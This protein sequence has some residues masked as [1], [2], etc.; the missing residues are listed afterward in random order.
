MTPPS[1]SRKCCVNKMTPHHPPSPYHHRESVVSTKWQ[2]TSKHLQ[3]CKDSSKP[4]WYLSTFA[5]IFAKCRQQQHVY[6]LNS[7]QN[8]VPLWCA[9]SNLYLAHIY[10][11][12]WNKL[13][14]FTSIS[15]NNIPTSN[16]RRK[17]TII[18]N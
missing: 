6:I 13:W 2:H 1:S 17:K 4:S 7:R 5:S 18:L 12:I 11:T 9:N 16:L 8:Q 10:T 14:G 15:T 3:R